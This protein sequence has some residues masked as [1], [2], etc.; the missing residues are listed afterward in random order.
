MNR[1]PKIGI[2][3]SGLGGLSVVKELLQSSLAYDLIYL[4]DTARLPYGAKS[5]E[6]VIRYSHD[7]AQF[8]MSQDVDAIVI[9]CHTASAFALESLQQRFDIPFVSMIPLACHK[10]LE[11]TQTQHIGIIGTVATVHSRS[12]EEFL[13]KQES[14]LVVDARAC[15]LLVSLAEEG[16]ID[17]SLTYAII[18]KYLSS[19]VAN[20][21]DTIILGCTH[22]PVLKSLIQKSVGS[23]VYL[24]DPAREVAT[25]LQD[26]CDVTYMGT[27]DAPMS[28]RMYVTDFVQRFSDV[29]QIFLGHSIDVNVD[30]VKIGQDVCI[31]TL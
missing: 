24:V 27:D 10:A 20:K 16:W 11:M 7:N 8:L 31:A 14:Q 5:R 13:L 1:R 4:G 29:S 9:A 21:M 15:A 23:D 6:T 25:C 18:D 19:F 12:Y 26:L 28:L 17:S 30:K 3:D 2:F 22:F